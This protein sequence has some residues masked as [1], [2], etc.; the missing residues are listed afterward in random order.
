MAIRTAVIGAGRI[1]SAHAKIY[2]SLQDVRLV[3]IADPAEKARR[4]AGE[5][6]CAATDDYRSLAGEVDAVSVA[7]PTSLHAEVAGF[8]LD[9]GVHC[10]VEKPLARSSVEARRLT[11]LAVA[12]GV[13]LQV[14]HVERFNAAVVEAAKHIADP[15]YIEAS[16]VSPFP[17]RSADVS[18][19]MDMMIHDIDLILHLVGSEVS[20]VRAS[21]APIL[22]DKE[23]IAS[24]RIE[25]ASGAVAS[26][27]ASRVAFKTERKMR[28]F[29]RGGYVSVDLLNRTV[30][31]A[32]KREALAFG[33]I[34]ISD[35]KP[36]DVGPDPLAFA[37]KNLI[38]VEE[39]VCP[40]G[41][42]LK[43]EIESFVS[44]VRSGSTPL[45]TG[46]H[47]VLAVETAERI[48]AAAGRRP[49]GD[50]KV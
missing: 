14:G 6:G 25:F 28:V 16:R 32:R 34:R 48:L 50:A 19:I 17:F 35:L 8:F 7:V 37:L 39:I 13:K 31:L 38:E 18:V 41:N 27:T 5:L 36:E 22:S 23:D 10:L 47:G 9:R 43:E 4:L 44:C 49:G 45:V 29:S 20:E 40:A 11:D 12:R 33:K 26:V 24:A 3:A 30:T 1:G 42:A 21:G 15:L 2:A 46:R